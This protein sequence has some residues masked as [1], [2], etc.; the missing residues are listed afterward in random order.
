MSTLTQLGYAIA[1]DVHRNFRRAAKACAV[2][3]PTLSTQLQKLEDELG[4]ILFDRKRLPV[5]PTAAGALLLAQFREVVAAHARID[6]VVDALSGRVAGPYRLGIIPTMAP[7][8][9][10]RLVPP[11]I[12]TYPQVELFVEELT[13]PEIIRRLHTEA[14]D[15][16]ILATPLNEPSLVEHPIGAEDFVVFHAAQSHFDADPDGRIAV[17]DLPTEQ[18]IVMREGHCLRTQALDLC[19]LGDAAGATH[20]FHIEAGSV[21]TLCAMVQQGPYF[22]ILPALAAREMAA[23]GHGALIKEIAGEV[24]F[25]EI[26][27]VTRAAESRRGIRAALLEAARAALAPL[28]RTERPRRAR[29]IAPR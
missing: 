15:G 28:T 29:P 24:P 25:R 7:T 11:F 16:A 10:P 14:L 20:R 9:L 5:T 1:V 27:F 17:A 23:A 2:S 22:T 26:A 3:Q 12:A 18:L 19:A 21:A 6:E 8:I 13:T 4:V